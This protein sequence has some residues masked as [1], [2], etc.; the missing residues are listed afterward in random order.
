[1]TFFAQ[2]FKIFRTN[3]GRSITP[4]QPPSLPP[5]RIAAQLQRIRLLLSQRL[6]HFVQWSQFVETQL[7]DN[8]KFGQVVEIKS[9]RY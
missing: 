4:P 8:L 1:M 5:V 3:F 2:R 9:H 6:F 7:C